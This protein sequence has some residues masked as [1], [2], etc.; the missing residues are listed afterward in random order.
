MFLHQS[1]ITYDDYVY[2][3]ITKIKNPKVFLRR[4]LQDIR[5][6]GYNEIL[7]N[8]HKANIDVKFILGPY[9]CVQYILTYLNKPDRNL[10]KL[11]R[12]Q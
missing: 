8:L 6:N 12:K 5:V 1:I 11:L 2:T 3:I 4:D 10:S 9:G 7:L